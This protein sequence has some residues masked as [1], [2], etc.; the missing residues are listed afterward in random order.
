MSVYGGEEHTICVV[1]LCVSIFLPTTRRGTCRSACGQW[2]HVNESWKTWHQV[3]KHRFP[4]PE[5]PFVFRFTKSMSLFSVR[6]VYSGNSTTYTYPFP[7]ALRSE[8]CACLHM[9]F[10]QVQLTFFVSNWHVSQFSLRPS[11]KTKR[12][13]CPTVIT[14][15]VS[16]FGQNQCLLAVPCKHGSLRLVLGGLRRRLL[17]ETKTGNI[18]QL[19]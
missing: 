15:S 4:A 2:N 9:L 10:L 13:W 19:P 16:S 6:G 18:F 1:G 14:P 12:R 8:Q 17:W 5:D 7:S 3:S 11:L